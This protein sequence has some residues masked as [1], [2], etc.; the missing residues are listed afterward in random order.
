M[1]PPPPAIAQE[2][3]A[4]NV[5]DDAAKITA[6]EA[7]EV[8]EVA[9]RFVRR[10]QE[11][12]DLAP[13]IGEMFVSDYAERLRQE[14]INNS[15]FL[16][17]KSV[18]EGASREELARYSLAFNNCAYVA[19]LLLFRYRLAHAKGNDDND[20]DDDDDSLEYFKKAVPPDILKLFET[21]PILKGLFVD[22][23]NDPAGEAAPDGQVEKSNAD[24]DVQVKPFDADDDELIRNVEQLRSFTSTLEMGATLARKHLG[25]PSFNPTLLERHEGLNEE[26]NWTAERE[27][28]K[29]R[30]W[31]LTREFYGY[32]KD[33]R[34]L[35]ANIMFYHM[36]LV[37]VNGKLKVLALYY[38]MD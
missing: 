8:L 26:A 16:M 4:Q 6:E 20:G 37:R 27:E 15:L 13:L 12:N 2:N 32:P 34:L 31:V 21:E 35:C 33:T 3:I 14:A 29:P 5:D 9:E 22:D 11:T 19:G 38:N 36:D 30:A 17:S 7:R 25:E 23:T 28:M 24:D 18:A 10:M 1:T